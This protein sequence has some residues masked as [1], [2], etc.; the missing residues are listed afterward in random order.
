MENQKLKLDDLKVQSF[1]TDFGKEQNQTREINGG[2]SFPDYCIPTDWP[3]RVT[4]GGS[5][6]GGCPDT[7]YLETIKDRLR[8]DILGGGEPPILEGPDVFFQF[9]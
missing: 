9:R 5:C 8:T 3:F 1:V 6:G 7:T 2:A 4:V